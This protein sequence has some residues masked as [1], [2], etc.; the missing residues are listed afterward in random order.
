MAGGN[1]LQ[2][3]DQN[4]ETDVLQSEAPVLVDFWAEWCGPCKAL[5]PV[6]DELANDY[7]GKVKVGKVNTDENSGL[8]LRYSVSAIPTVILFHKGE[9]VDRFVGLRSKK[10]FKTLLDRVVSV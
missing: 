7:E 10:D 8:S 5:G 9:I 2:F 6:I 1:T 3:T 4:F